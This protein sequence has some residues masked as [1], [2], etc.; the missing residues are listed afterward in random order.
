[1]DKVFSGMKYVP[2]KCLARFQRLGRVRTHI[3]QILVGL[4]AGMAVM[5]ASCSH[6]VAPGHVQERRPGPAGSPDGR[7]LLSRLE[8]AQAAQRKAQSLKAQQADLLR[9]PPPRF[10]IKTS[11]SVYR[12][13]DTIG[14]T[15]T[16]VAPDGNPPWTVCTFAPGSVSVVFIK[17]NGVRLSESSH[18]IADFPDSPFSLQLMS[19]V[20]LLP[21]TAV[22]IPFPLGTSSSG[23]A[24]L[25]ETSD[26]G[27]YSVVFIDPIT[28]EQTV[29][30]V[31]AFDTKV[32][33]FGQPGTYSIKLRYHFS[34][35]LLPS[36]NVCTDII[37]S[38]EV[39]LTIQ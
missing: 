28:K 12:L 4:P 26:R 16:L 38:N 34:G 2:T 1:M 15:L 18:S 5:L 17:R 19:L 32:Y 30:E 9:P 25:Y 7:E 37:D 31:P 23:A 36:R 20:D 13:G 14:L 22:R 29:T 10:I 24:L 33:D 35:G 21:G 6:P 8:Q 27:A 3:T 39:T 11:A